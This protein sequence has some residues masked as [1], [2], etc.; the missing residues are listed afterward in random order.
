MFLLCLPSFECWWLAPWA[1]DKISTKCFWPKPHIA[2]RSICSAG[3]SMYRYLWKEGSQYTRFPLNWDLHFY[4][5]WWIQENK[6]APLTDC[7][8]FS[9]RAFPSKMISALI[10]KW[11]QIVLAILW[12][13]QSGPWEPE[14]RSLWPISPGFADAQISARESVT[15]ASC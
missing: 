8:I 3:G 13:P 9:T 14:K 5:S 6:N 2:F 1:C 4:L 15:T 7:H 11:Y 12:S 10:I